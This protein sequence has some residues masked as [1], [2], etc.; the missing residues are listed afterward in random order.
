VALDAEPRPEGRGQQTAARRGSDEREGGQFDLDRTRRRTLV[1]YDVDLVVLHRRIEILLDDRAEAVDFVDE[2]HVARVEVG[3]QAGQVARL[4]QHGTRRDAQ[5]RPHL[6]GD[7][8][9][10]RR[11][12]Q[13][14]RSVQQHVVQRVA[15]HERRLDEDAEVLDDLVLSR[16]VLELLRADPVLEF[17]VALCIAYDRHAAKIANFHETPRRPAKKS[18]PREGGPDGDLR[19]RSGYCSCGRSSLMCFVPFSQVSI[20][21]ITPFFPSSSAAIGVRSNET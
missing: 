18:G 13:S 12:A 9:R 7:D 1:E 16:E 19:V 15:A 14:R 20:P 21:R 11:L 17:E 4:V 5:L 3:Q 10:Q 8:I 6:V 2:E